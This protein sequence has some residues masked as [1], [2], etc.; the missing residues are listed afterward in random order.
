[1]L[2]PNSYYV[3]SSASSNN[4]NNN[5]FTISNNNHVVTDNNNNNKTIM[6]K[7]KTILYSSIRRYCTIKRCIISFV[8]SLIIIFYFIIYPLL[9]KFWLSGAMVSD[10]EKIID[11]NGNNQVL[12]RRHPDR[13]KKMDSI[14]KELIPKY[15]VLYISILYLILFFRYFFSKIYK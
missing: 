2:R 15:V 3:P 12:I 7:I 1:M 5:S 4:N 9:W 8:I 10:M 14:T 6:M 13:M 11:R